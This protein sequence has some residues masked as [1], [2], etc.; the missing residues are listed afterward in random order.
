MGKLIDSIKYAVAELIRRWNINF[1]VYGD[2]GIE[3]ENSKV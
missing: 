1:S 3:I 2:L